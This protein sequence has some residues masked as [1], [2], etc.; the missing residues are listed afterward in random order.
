[1]AWYVLAP[2][3]WWGAARDQAAEAAQRIWVISWR[4]SLP[5]VWM[6]RWLT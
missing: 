2:V 1:M 3:W 4:S 6:R 5:P